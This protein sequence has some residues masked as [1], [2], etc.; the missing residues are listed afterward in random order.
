VAS[1]VTVLL[2]VIGGVADVGKV[3][4]GASAR[5]AEIAETGGAAEVGN[6][7]VVVVLRRAADAHQRGDRERKHAS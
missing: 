7:G 5:V 2:W 3:G 6:V 1:V 4:R